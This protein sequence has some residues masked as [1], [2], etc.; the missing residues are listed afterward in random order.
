MVKGNVLTDD[1]TLELRRDMLGVS[2]ESDDPTACLS[3]LLPED[4]CAREALEGSTLPMRQGR[5]R[6][7]RKGALTSFIIRPLGT[8]LLQ[9]AA[10]ETEKCENMNY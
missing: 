8:L 4:K 3:A 5:G 1:S 10:G 7:A 9:A 6:G 2:A